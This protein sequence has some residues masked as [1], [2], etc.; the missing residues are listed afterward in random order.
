M[1]IVCGKG[2]AYGEVSRE[3]EN[4][5]LEWI[6]SESI[7]E[8]EFSTLMD[9]KPKKIILNQDKESVWVSIQV[10]GK[11][12][13]SPFVWNK[14]SGIKFEVFYTDLL[15]VLTYISLKYKD[16]EFNSEVKKCYEL[17]RNMLR[18]SNN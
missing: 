2:Q 16:K 18:F 6:K 3:I 17:L 8:S 5:F 15:L 1:K 4:I 11:L 14:K 7:T 13:V 9:R 10:G 12:I